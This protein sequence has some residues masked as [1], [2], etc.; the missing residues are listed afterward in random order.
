[1]A[2]DARGQGEGSRW[3]AKLLG[4]R[5]S[6]AVG[7]LLGIGAFVSALFGGGANI[8][9]GA[10]GV[11]LGVLGYFLGSRKLATATVVLCAATILFGLAA[12]QGLI[13]G[14]PSSDHAFPSN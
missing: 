4:G 14:I 11:A 10:L 7:L 13:P 3:S 1:M 8:S 9:A 2:E 6:C 5:I 12:S